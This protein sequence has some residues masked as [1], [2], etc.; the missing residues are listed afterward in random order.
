MQVLQPMQRAGIHH[1]DAGLLILPGGG[2]WADPHTGWPV[3]LI[4][5]DRHEDRLVLAACNGPASFKNLGAKSVDRHI[6]GLDAGIHAP[7]A[8]DAVFLPDHHRVMRAVLVLPDFR[9][10]FGGP[11][12]TDGGQRQY[13]SAQIDTGHRQSKLE[14]SAA[15]DGRQSPSR[16]SLSSCCNSSI[17]ILLHSLLISRVSLSGRQGSVFYSSGRLS[18]DAA[19]GT[20][21][22][23][24]LRGG[25]GTASRP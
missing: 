14:K 23:G 9:N 17:F 25:H 5:E 20:F 3:A 22:N 1:H 10:Q 8:V 4:A 21:L 12:D 2:G 11:G 16:F 19:D 18:G 7:F 6:V 24:L 15:F 13:R